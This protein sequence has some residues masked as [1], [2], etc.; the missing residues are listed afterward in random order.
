MGLDLMATA[1]FDPEQAVVLWH[2]MA[3]ASKGQPPE[4]MSSHPAHSTR[5]GELEARM[6]R[7]EALYTQAQEAGRKPH[8]QRPPEDREAS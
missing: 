8:C 4:W 3:A 1:G 7:A 2:N 5:I 6:A